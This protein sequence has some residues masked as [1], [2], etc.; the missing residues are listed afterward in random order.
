M[1]VVSDW[2]NKQKIGFKNILNHH[3]QFS[4]KDEQVWVGGKWDPGLEVN[5]YKQ[6]EAGGYGCGRIIVSDLGGILV[7]FY[8]ILLLTQDNVWLI[9]VR[10]TKDVFHYI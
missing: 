3:Q 7:Y 10:K 2:V 4:H 8:I 6:H 9:D 1:L 5:L